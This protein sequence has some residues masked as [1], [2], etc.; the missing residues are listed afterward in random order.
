[1]HGSEALATGMFEPLPDT[2]TKE[3]WGKSSPAK[4]FA[5]KQLDP[6]SLRGGDAALAIALG[7][8]SEPAAAAACL[9]DFSTFDVVPIF[10]SHTSVPLSF[11][12]CEKL[13]VL[14][15]SALLGVAS[16]A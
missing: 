9:G 15:L 4:Y 13:S 14:A 16:R 1:M 6:E 7:L 5:S 12:T 8:H 10:D 3:T 2:K 11:G